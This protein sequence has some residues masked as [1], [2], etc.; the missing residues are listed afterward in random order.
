MKKVIK[1]VVILVVLAV[2]VSAVMHAVNSGGFKFVGSGDGV[3]DGEPIT[4]G[5]VGPL[6]GDA[7]SYGEPIRNAVALAVEEV[8]AEGGVDGRPLEV[9]YEDGGCNGKDA[10]NAAQKLVNIDGVAAIIG[11]VC[12]GEALAMVPITGPAG[13][14]VLSPSASSPEL[15]EK[16][17]EYFF[18]NNP[19][20]S[21][22]GAFLADVV[23]RNHGTVAV[24]SENTDYAQAL[25]GVFINRFRELGG[26]VV[27]DESF[28]DGTSDFRTILTKVKAANP[29]AIF[30]NPQTEI[31][32][33]AIVKQI[34]E[35]GV[36]GA[37]FGSNILSG[38]E[39]IKIAGDAVEGLVLFDSP[40]L[41]RSGGNPM[42]AHFIREYESR[43]GAL[44]I[45]F[46]LGAAY[47]A[48]YILTEA[49]R[50]AGVYDSEVLRAYLHTLPVFDGVV[51]SY[52]FDGN[53]DMV[54]INPVL[55]QISGGQVV[56]IEDSAAANEP[57]GAS[58][59][60]IVPDSDQDIF[61]PAGS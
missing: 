36:G 29:G 9:V 30:I 6:T 21:S 8:N 3:S 32:G 18:R 49:L 25:R 16:G 24:I 11:G 43:Y 19:S 51:G 59:P 23:I 46:Y 2:V 10:A 61:V 7:V 54:G 41:A 40:G 17:G 47:D 14:V 60:V 44:S 57:S 12:S 22:G 38:S 53:G 56:I 5:F 33:A 13:V 58:E 27:A 48:V 42:V 4:I 34:A 28:I 39:T 45:E 15:T 1:V 52:S 31:A 50:A 37:L 35:L 55:K 20:D 26:T